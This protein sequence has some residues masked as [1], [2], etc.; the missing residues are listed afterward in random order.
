[1]SE[2]SK[3]G[4]VYVI[5]DDPD[6]RDSLRVRLETAGYDVRLYETASAFLKEYEPGV[7]CLILD[8]HLTDISGLE[9]QR[10]LKERSE[11]LPVIMVT[12]YPEL[13]KAV[14]AMKLGAFDFI[15]KPFDD[16]VLLAGIEQAL[17]RSERDREMAAMRDEAVA[18]LESLTARERDVLVR[19]FSGASSRSIAKTLGIS[20][21]TVEVHRANI[22]R[23]VNVQNLAEL[24]QLASRA[25]LHWERPLPPS[26]H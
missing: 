18:R 19:V 5:D 21:R 9:L 1:M 22:M 25:G 14:E 12:A 10:L 24:L 17:V 2:N 3:T 15:E 20:Q 26:R 7:G 23:K 8:L 6:V 16:Q 13:A 11:T 4:P